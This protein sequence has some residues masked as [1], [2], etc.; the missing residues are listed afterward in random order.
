MIARNQESRDSAPKDSPSQL[1]ELVEHK[2]FEWDQIS[3]DW[4]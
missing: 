3:H 4:V 1:G 2:K